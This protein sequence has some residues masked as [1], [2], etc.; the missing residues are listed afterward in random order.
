[1]NQQPELSEKYKKPFRKFTRIL[2]WP[3]VVITFV[4]IYD[5]IA[6]AAKFDQALITRKSTNRSKSGINYNIQAKGNFD[7]YEKVNKQFYNTA[8]I[9]DT[10]NVALSRFFSEW[11]SIELV[12]N[13]KVII[14]TTGVDLYFMGMFG[15]LFLVPLFAFLPKEKLFSN[16]LLIIFIP[17]IEL[18][19][20]LLWIKLILVLAGVIEKM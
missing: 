4:I 15:L 16:L 12:R 18:I 2:A 1:M 14:K 3:S 6:P 13:D 7:Y 8:L 19:A 17:V 10:I 11:K 20:I 5:I 9:G